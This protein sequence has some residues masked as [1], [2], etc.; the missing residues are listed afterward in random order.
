MTTTETTE[1]MEFDDAVAWAHSHTGHLT[2]GP[3]RTALLQLVAHYLRSVQWRSPAGEDITV[4]YNRST[5]T[6]TGEATLRS[7]ER[8]G[9]TLLRELRHSHEID[10]TS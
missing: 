6:F 4:T 10:G 2:D 3:T 8:P 5:E 1:P 7:A 9:T